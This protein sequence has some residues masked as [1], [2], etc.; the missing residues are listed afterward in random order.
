M[1]KNLRALRNEKGISQ[2]QLADVI[3]V[4]QQSVNKYENHD[5]E[6]DID[7]LIKIADYFDV[8]LDYLVGRT[9]IKEMVTKPKMSD[10]SEKEAN[11]VQRLRYLKENQKDFVFQLIDSYKSDKE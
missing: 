2:Q 7:V 4:S 10:L 11:F 8:S 3:L 5:V 6:P 1:I 9:D